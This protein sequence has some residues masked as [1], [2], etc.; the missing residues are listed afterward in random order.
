M[1][2]RKTSLK[3]DLVPEDRALL[4]G[5][6]RSATIP[7]GLARRSWIILQVADGVPITHIADTVGISRR[8]VYKWAER[9]IDYGL[10]GLL[11]KPGRGYPLGPTKK[12]SKGNENV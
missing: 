9:F 2:G 11:D 6:Q 12:R 5:W 4:A 8:H 1:R 7:A 10:N 3:I